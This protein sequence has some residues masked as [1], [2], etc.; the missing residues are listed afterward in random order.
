MVRRDISNRKKDEAT[1]AD[2]ERLLALLIDSVPANIALFSADERYRFVNR[3]YETMFDQ[4]GGEIIG[5][6][7]RDIVG[8]EGYGNVAPYLKKAL[9]GEIAMVEADLEYPRM[10]MR[11]MQ[12]TLVPDVDV[13]GTVQGVFSIAFDVTEIRRVSEE[14]KRAESTLAAAIQASPAGIVVADGPDGIIRLANKAVCDMTGVSCDQLIGS[15]MEDQAVVWESLR[16]DGTVSSER[17]LSL[18]RAVRSGAVVRDDE[19]V[20]RRD[21]G[22]E[23]WVLANAAPTFDSEGRIGGSVV[24]LVD[25]TERKHIEKRLRQ[26]ESIIQT[27]P[28]VAFLWRNDE[29]WPVE[30]VR[31]MSNGF[32]AILPT[33]LPLAGSPT[34]R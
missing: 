25:I 11:R 2:R 13:D 26:A 32:S 31:Q 34:H 17:T 6:H 14:L 24:V 21:D 19:A 3:R 8:E 23:R 10:G 15:R 7:V 22:E 9:G 18:S 33:T 5:R 30:Y 28:V 12:V 20:L 29:N 1:L 4:E 16:A 27:G